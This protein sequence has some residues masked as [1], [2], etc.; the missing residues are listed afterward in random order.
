MSV[1]TRREAFRCATSLLRRLAIVATV[2][3]GTAGAALAVW[4]P[5]RADVPPAGP[6]VVAAELGASK[7]PAALVVLVDVSKSMSASN[8]GL[9]PQVRS[10]LPKFLAALARQDPQDRVAVVVFGTR[11][12]TQTIYPMG[13]PK[14]NIPLPPD[15][16]S[17]GTDIGYAFEKALANLGQAPKNMQVGG[18]LLLSD[19]GINAPDDPTYD[20]GA[21]YNAPGWAKLAIQAQGLGIPITGYGLPLTDDPN[22]VQAL[23][24]ALKAGFGAQR[25]MLAPNVSDLGSQL[26]VAQQK[27]L[28]ARVAG[29]A[30]PDSGRGVRVTWHGSPADGGALHLDLGAGHA[31]LP[32]TFTAT[33]QRVPLHATDLSVRSTGFPASVTGTVSNSDVSLEPGRPVTVA[34]HLTWQR[35][36]GGSSLMAAGKSWRG[37]LTL[38]ARVYSPFS[39]A[40]QHYYLDKSFTV[41]GLADATSAEFPATAPGSVNLLEW[42]LILLLVAALLAAF[43]VYRARLGGT[44]ILTTVRG[45]TGEVPLPPRP[46]YSWRTDQ[47]IGIP[48]DMSVRGSPLS[49]KM[50]IRLRNSRLPDSEITLMPGERTMIAGIDVVHQNGH[51]A[52]GGADLGRR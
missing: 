4:T 9:Y 7:I 27:I 45:E 39:N 36:A 29:A 21:G 12:D 16:T 47:L 42:L 44:L 34:V 14:T 23:D 13:R 43:C 24:A 5:A 30:G 46:W 18:I 48:G 25:Q 52:G 26:D 31:D 11:S 20:G 49:S 3:T 41:G 28:N 32:V 10:E 35:V 37:Q 2:A 40:I 50:W 19:G 33:T 17:A 51:P 22:D 6:S 38:N 8:D 15:A 1:S